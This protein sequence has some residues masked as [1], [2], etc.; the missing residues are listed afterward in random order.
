MSSPDPPR[1]GPRVVPL[2]LAQSNFNNG[3][4]RDLSLADTTTGTPYSR[5]RSF[6]S[7]ASLENDRER[8][9][10]RDN[11]EPFRGGVKTAG[12]IG[13]RVDRPEEDDPTSPNTIMCATPATAVPPVDTQRM[14][15]LSV[16]D[17]GYNRWNSNG[18]PGPQSI[19]SM[20]AQR[21]KLS[22]TSNASV[23]RSKTLSQMR[24][25]DDGSHGSESQEDEDFSLT[26]PTRSRRLSLRRPETQ[27]DQEASFTPAGTF[28]SSSFL[29]P[30]TNIKGISSNSRRSS[31]RKNSR[32]IDPEIATRMKR[33]ID[34]IVVCNF[35]LDRGPVVERRMAGRPWAKGEKANV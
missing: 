30:G 2:E 35:D 1:P 11:L 26:T 19:A 4:R 32:F 18:D 6:T 13:S 29:D 27:D 22:N 20:S 25:R 16:R 23:T 17:D 24:G 8:F 12:E 15:S 21:R 3:N 5:Q 31:Y 7:M 14:D 33:W 34:E 10:E 9:Y 28:S